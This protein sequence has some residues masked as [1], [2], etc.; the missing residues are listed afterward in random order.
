[1]SQSIED[2]ELKELLECGIIAVD[3][4]QGPSSHQVTAWVKEILGGEQRIGH[5]GTLDPMVSG[6]LIVMLGRAVRLAPVILKHRKEYIAVL[7]L[8]GDVDKD[9]VYRVAE[10]FRGRVYQ[11]PPRKS[12]VRRQLRIR[13]IYDI[14]ILDFK[15]RLVLLKVACEAGSYIRSLCTHLALAMGVGGQMEELRRSR[16]GSLGLPDTCTL[17]D[18][19]DAYVFAGEGNPEELKKMIL[20]VERLV[21]EIPVV[22]IR[23]SAVEAVCSGALLAGVGVVS[24]ESCKRDSRVAVVTEKGELVCIGKALISSEEYKPG[25]TG[26]VVAPQAVVMKRGTYEKGWTKHDYREKKQL[27]TEEKEEK[28]KEA[29][30]MANYHKSD[31]PAKSSKKGEKREYTGKKRESHKAERPGRTTKQSEG[32]K[33]GENRDRSYKPERSLRP[34]GQSKGP[35]YGENRDRSYKPERSLRPAGQSD[36]PYSSERKSEFQ[37]SDRP[38]RT[39]GRTD[40]PYSA[41]RKSEFQRSD[42]PPRTQGRTDRPYSAEKKSEFQRSDRPPRTQGRTDRPYSAER[43]SEY[44]KSDRP[45]T[46]G[47][48]D[49]PYSAERKSEF[50]K[51]DRPRTTGR[52][53]RP[54]SAE[55]KSEFQKSDRPRTTG[56]TDRPYSAERK[57]EYQKSERPRTTGRTE[58]PYSA[59][60]KS[61]Y[62]RAE[63]PAGAQRRTE[64]APGQTDRPYNSG[65]KTEYSKPER[66]ERPVRTDKKTERKPTGSQKRKQE[67]THDRESTPKGRTG[68]QPYEKTGK[69]R[70]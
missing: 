41:E 14:E 23:D 52:T 28:P 61:E 26:F 5:G 49:R 45:R 21:S 47:R 16:S 62:Q 27:E 3:K 29:E 2:P 19:K 17:Q 46:T 48:T 70:K 40:R 42:R 15:D 59:E 10:E 34:A 24:K 67:R 63:R 44:Q 50:Q 11:R 36:R 7:R 53:D 68:F 1:M 60:R 65:R 51:S 33:Y 38:P 6:V 18:L 20:P 9:E 56:R 37:R 54:Y 31:R 39:Q 66:S 43:K 4:P 32:P 64:R 35:K 12:A 58:R 30:E 13:T 25:D 22:M 55:R 8:H 69:T 57:S